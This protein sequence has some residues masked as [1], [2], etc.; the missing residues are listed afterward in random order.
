MGDR[1]S[2]SM[3]YRKSDEARYA[4]VLGQGW[5]DDVEDEGRTWRR[6]FAA[7]VNYGL[8]GERETLA[9]QGLCFV[10][11]HGAGCDYGAARFAAFGGEQAEVAELGGEMI[12]PLDE[13]GD[14]QAK[15]MAS[16]QRYLE[17]LAQAREE[18][19]LPDEDPAC[20][21]CYQLIR[22]FRGVEPRLLGRPVESAEPALHE[23]VRECLK[24]EPLR[25]EDG[26]FYL[27]LRNGRPVSIQTFGVEELE[28]LKKEAG[29][30]KETKEAEG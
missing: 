11:D 24:A 23:A 5:Y 16:V 8:S 19:G 12:V 4:G 29:E 15:S 27:S 7:E 25:E 21:A 3:T 14:L 26:L 1:C 6:I 22:I 2:L 28:R 17:L 30:R 13:D 20:T 10:G 9:S 18:L